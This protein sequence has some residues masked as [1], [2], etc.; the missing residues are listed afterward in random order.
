MLKI[1]DV[2]GVMGSFFPA[3]SIRAGEGASGSVLIAAGAGGGAC[4]SDFFTAGGGAGGA[5]D[6]AFF[7]AGVDGFEATFGDGDAATTVL[8]FGIGF[9]AVEGFADAVLFAVFGFGAAAGAFVDFALVVAGF[10]IVSANSD[11]TGSETTF[12]G[13]PLFFTTSEDILGSNCVGNR[14]LSSMTPELVI[15]RPLEKIL[16]VTR[17]GNFQ[18][19]FSRERLLLTT[20]KIE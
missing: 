14:C 18:G 3:A 5:L 2:S 20:K 10:L 9:A 12:L 8:G 11:S 19:A 6:S 1:L 15:L 17:F 7:T 13:L 16:S 4:G